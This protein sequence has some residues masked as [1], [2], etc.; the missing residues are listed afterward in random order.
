MTPAVL[1]IRFQ[2]YLQAIAGDLG[3]DRA[4]AEADNVGVIVLA[5]QAGA[6][7]VMD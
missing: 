2:K 6:Q 5:R 3:A 1:E 4:A 7:G